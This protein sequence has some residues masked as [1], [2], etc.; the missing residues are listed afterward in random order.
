MIKANEFKV[1][2][3]IK[4]IIIVVQFIAIFFL[5]SHLLTQK[6]IIRQK[7]EMIKSREGL[8]LK[9]EKAAKSLEL[10]FDDCFEAYKQCE[11]TK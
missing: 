3:Y 2:K 7:N 1:S 10:L 9:W 8:L 5:I 4:E 6:N 11:K